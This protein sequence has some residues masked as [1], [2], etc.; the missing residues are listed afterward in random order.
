[1]SYQEITNRGRTVVLLKP[2]NYIPSGKLLI[3]FHGWLF[4][5]HELKRGSDPDAGDPVG[6]TKEYEF[7]KTL[8]EVAS[9][10]AMIIPIGLFGKGAYSLTRDY[11]SL[12]GFTNLVNLVS[13]TIGERFSELTLS[14]HSAAYNVLTP[15][16]QFQD[17]NIARVFSFDS[18][19]SSYVS[20]FTRWLS[21]DRSHYFY[22]AAIQGTSPN[23]NASKITG[24]HYYNVPS[25][26]N[27]HWGVPKYYMKEFLK[28]SR[29]EV[30][31]NGHLP[32]VIT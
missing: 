32:V 9:D 14:G 12:K 27:D 10:T 22:N 6:V 15:L 23:T 30:K 17:L 20:P 26:I 4:R 29:L 2:D 11:A 24:E 25:I 19:Y 8:T 18:L 16:V 5:S 28:R 13:E 31:L 3:H 1:M 7:E 21:L